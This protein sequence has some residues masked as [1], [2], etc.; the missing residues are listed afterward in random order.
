M[1]CGAPE[2][3]RGAGRDEDEEA[4]DGAVLGAERAG[5]PGE[6]LPFAGALRPASSLGVARSVSLIETMVG[7]KR[8][9]HVGEMNTGQR[10]NSRG[11]AFRNALLGV[12]VVA[13]LGWA[14][15]ATL[16]APNYPTN[17]GVVEEG[18]IYRAAAM[19]P[20]ATKRVVEERGI[21]TIIDLGAF[22]KEPALETVA[23]RTAEA[24]G[25][26]RYLFPLEGDGRGNPN[27]YVAALRVLN[28]PANRPVLVHCSAGAQRT[29][30]CMVLYRHIVQG[31]NFSDVYH[32][33]YEHRHDP[34]DNRV[35]G[36]YLLDWA[37]AIERAF[38]DGGWIPGRP[39][40]QGELEGKG[41]GREK[42]ANTP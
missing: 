16:I 40:F 28:D 4:A 35:M 39:D 27:A 5:T 19:N 14:G 38:R 37:P 22:D 2:S 33:A 18:R 30:A 13:A 17:F 42:P 12:V 9:Y 31:K 26:K 24:L 11:R 32:E 6:A 23:E 15:Y 8:E 3:L 7:P 34:G 36:P 20:A 41:V 10:T 25:V 1:D 21:K 29:S